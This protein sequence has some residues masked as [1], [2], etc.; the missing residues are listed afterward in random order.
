[1]LKTKFNLSTV[2]KEKGES[3]KQF[4]DYNKSIIKISDEDYLK[5]KEF[6]KA[7][8]KKNFY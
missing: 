3:L 4:N 1:M 2:V 6:V 7:E 8:I 5:H